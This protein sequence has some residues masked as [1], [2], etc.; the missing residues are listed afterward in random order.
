MAGFE[1]PHEER[2][3]ELIKTLVRKFDVL[4]ENFKPGTMERW[5]LG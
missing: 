3:R 5:G 4:I 2:G 1:Y